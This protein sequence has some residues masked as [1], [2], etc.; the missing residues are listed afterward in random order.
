MYL[1]TLGTTHLSGPRLTPR[2]LLFLAFLAVEGSVSRA[3]LRTLFWPN[4]TSAANSLRV[5]L[6]TMRR[7]APGLFAE[8]GDRLIMQCGSDLADLLGHLQAGRAAQAL[9]LYRGPFLD[10]L[11]P[12]LFGPE[13]EEWLMD[14]RESI[15]EQLWEALVHSAE[16]LAGQGRLDE[17]T[18]Q[19][20]AAWQLPGLPP[21]DA[22]DLQRLHRLLILGSSKLAG[23]VAREAGELGLN[24]DAYRLPPPEP[25][26]SSPSTVHLPL[27]VTPFL[28][29]RD[30]LDQMSQTLADPTTRLLTIFGMGGAGKSRLALQLARQARH[31][32]QDQV[33]WIPLEDVRQ[34]GDLLSHTAL[35]LGINVT[36][37]RP[38]RDRHGTARPSRTPRVRSVRASG[39]GGAPPRRAARPLPPPEDARDVPA[40]ALS[41]GRNDLRAARTGGAS[42]PGGDA[43]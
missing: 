31:T 6:S 32:Y 29:H 14:T 13:L 42:P 18:T 21:R 33:W 27:E 16:H 20:E 38:G 10:E 11:S 22:H 2:H 34:P 40:P 39:R 19:A 37:H 17:A 15:A 24:L 43:E 26:T 1:T 30:L 23:R 35:A 9:A 3:R 28:G 12:T 41:A 25:D 36:P 4:S 7:A 8:R 5:L